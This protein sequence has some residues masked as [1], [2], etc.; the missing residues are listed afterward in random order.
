MSCEP[1]I[2]YYFPFIN[3]L[4]L[5]DSKIH[6]SLLLQMG[7]NIFGDS[8]HLHRACFCLS[9]SITYFEEKVKICFSQLTLFGTPDCCL[10]L[11]VSV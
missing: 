7:K 11:F 8:Y 1:C 4:L 3:F 5:L 9:V 10:G 2:E 6:A